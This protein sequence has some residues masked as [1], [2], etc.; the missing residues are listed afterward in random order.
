MLFIVEYDCYTNMPIN[1]IIQSFRLNHLHEIT[2]ILVEKKRICLTLLS[3]V[4]FYF[5][6]EI[7]IR[8]FHWIF[9]T[10]NGKST[11]KCT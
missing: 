8:H 11:S 6:Q 5:G 7:L 4:T 2:K 1:K 10:I 9:F 3:G